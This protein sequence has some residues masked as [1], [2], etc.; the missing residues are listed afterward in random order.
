MIIKRNYVWLFEL[1]LILWFGSLT[2]PYIE[3]KGRSLEVGDHAGSTLGRFIVPGLDFGA[4]LR[5]LHR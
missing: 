3:E 4:V 2:T 1:L 5:I